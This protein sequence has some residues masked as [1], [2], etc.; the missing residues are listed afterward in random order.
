MGFNYINRIARKWQTEKELQ[1]QHALDMKMSSLVVYN[2]MCHAFKQGKLFSLSLV[3]E[4]L[5]YS[6]VIGEA[7]LTR[8]FTK[9]NES[10]AKANIANRYIHEQQ[11]EVNFPYAAVATPKMTA[12][13]AFRSKH[14]EENLIKLYAIEMVTKM[15]EIWCQ[16]LLQDEEEGVKAAIARDQKH[17]KKKRYDAARS[18]KRRHE[19]NRIAYEEAVKKREA[20]RIKFEQLMEK[21]EGSQK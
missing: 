3:D 17:M 9:I 21:R 6:K 4:V 18:L 14:D 2:T 19:R 13:E 20:N 1:E 8:E 11:G 5:K 7:T 16:S 12:L 15:Y 10:N